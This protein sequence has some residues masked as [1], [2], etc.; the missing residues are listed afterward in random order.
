M[1][2]EILKTAYSLEG[3]SHDAEK[4]SIGA[5]GLTHGMHAA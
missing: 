2:G 5:Y 3:Q 1:T 4:C